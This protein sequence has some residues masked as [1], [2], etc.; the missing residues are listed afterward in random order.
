MMETDMRRLEGKIA[1]ITGGAGGLGSACGERFAAE[2]ATVIVADL[3]EQAAK[4]VA[5][6]IGHGAIGL[7]Y[8]AGDPASIKA[9]I[10]E[11]IGRFGK[12]DILFNNAAA[13]SFEVH[14][15]DTTAPEIPIEIWDL[16]MNVNVRG[17]M[18]GCIYAI[19]HM[20][21]AGGGSIIN[22]ASDSGLAGDNVRVAYGT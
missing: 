9:G 17:V 7:H 1:I 12:I 10:D 18:L 21:A 3:F 6:Q 16:V 20:I 15:Q 2:G 19:P 14:Q 13:T 4:D 8:D 11:V 22:T 5:E